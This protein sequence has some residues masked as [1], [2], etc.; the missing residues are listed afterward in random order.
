MLYDDILRVDPAHPDRHDRDRFIL[1]KG[2]GCLALY[3]QL[4]ERGFF[5]A[6]GAGH[7]LRGRVAA[8]RASP[9]RQGPGRGGFHGLARARAAGRGR[10]RAARQADR[11][12]FPHGRAARR[13]RVRRGLGLGG[14]PLRRQAPAGAPHRARGL[15]QDAVLRRDGRGPRP[16]AARRQ[17]AQLRLCGARGRR[18]RRAR[19]APRAA[20]RAVRCRAVPRRSSATPSRGGGSRAARATRTGTTRAASPTPSSASSRSNS[21]RGAPCEEGLPRDDPRA[22]APRRARA[23]LRFGHRRRDTRRLPEG[24]SRGAFSWRGSRRRTSSGS[25]PASR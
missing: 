20:G 19:P 22:G 24:V 12:R 10:H 8:R 11:P 7:L 23:L 17:V 14:G 16:G 21:K 18:A 15:Q 2:H 5:P 3:V 4:A 9:G 6:R 13:R 25:C 1:S